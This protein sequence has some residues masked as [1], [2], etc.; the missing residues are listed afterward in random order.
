M[1]VILPVKSYANRREFS[2]NAL[3]VLPMILLSL[4]SQH[5][6]FPP[7]AACTVSRLIIL[8]VVKAAEGTHRHKCMYTQSRYFL[9]NHEIATTEGKYA[10]SLK[11]TWLL[12]NNISTSQRTE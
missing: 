6:A 1:F 3:K 8:P 2:R 10:V 12:S 9:D 7:S 11:Q 4:T 5:E